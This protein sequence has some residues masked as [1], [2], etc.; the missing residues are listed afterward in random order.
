MEGEASREVQRVIE[1]LESIGD[2]GERALAAGELLKNW[3]D[4]HRQVREIR[5][6]AVIVLRQQGMSH[7]DIAALLK[8]TKSRAA[9]IAEGRRTGRRKP[10]DAADGG[11]D[12][13]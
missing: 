10:A 2:A 3:P 9:Q 7:A 12:A 6:Q 8:V 1:G 4:L 5:Q 13:S 11:A